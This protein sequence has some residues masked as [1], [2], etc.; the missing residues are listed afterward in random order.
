MLGAH[1]AGDRK[2][3]VQ[4][5]DGVL[6]DDAPAATVRSPDSMAVGEVRV[7]L[8]AMGS[9]SRAC[10]LNGKD[11]IGAD[12]AKIVGTGMVSFTPDSRGPFWTLN[13]PVDGL[14]LSNMAVDRDQGRQG[15]GKLMVQV[16]EELSRKRHPG[17]RMYL[18]ARLQDDPALAL[19]RCACC[20]LN[21]VAL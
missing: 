5:V 4:I 13:P 20:S 7:V 18:H 10:A 3:A 14:F 6:V 15:I 11:L 21:C 16:C 12:E 9:L 8:M 17:C 1:G 19:Y 2:H